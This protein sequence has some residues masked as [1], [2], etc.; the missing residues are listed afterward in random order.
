V[1]GVHSDVYMEKTSGCSSKL[2]DVTWQFTV[3]VT[4]WTS[5]R[6]FQVTISDEAA[7]VLMQI[8]LHKFRCSNLMTSIMSPSQSTGINYS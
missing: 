3:T 5:L 2:H 6:G 4:L 7:A 1:K 8:L